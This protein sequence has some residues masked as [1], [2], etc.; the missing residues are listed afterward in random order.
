MY[1]A[2]R[3]QR[4]DQQDDLVHCYW[5]LLSLP[6]SILILQCNVSLCK[7]NENVP[8]IH[9]MKYH[10]Y[11]EVNQKKIEQNVLHHNMVTSVQIR[12][13]LDERLDICEIAHNDYCSIIFQQKS[14]DCGHHSVK[15]KI[16][17]YGN[18]LSFLQLR[19]SSLFGTTLMIT[20]STRQVIQNEVNNSSEVK[21]EMVHFLNLAIK[22]QFSVFLSRSFAN[23]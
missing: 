3:L 6:F 1:S 17:P 9:N 11:L 23:Y 21:I 14:E 7:L 5:F 22:I 2:I 18:I 4:F 8:V 15:I 13:H 12:N 20:F 16:E 19:L 10:K